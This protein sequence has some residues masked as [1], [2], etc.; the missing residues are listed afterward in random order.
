[1]M[2]DKHIDLYIDRSSTPLHTPKS[3][4]VRTGDGTIAKPV[5]TVVGD[6]IDYEKFMVVYNKCMAKLP[7]WITDLDADVEVIIGLKPGKTA[8]DGGWLLGY[9]WKRSSNKWDRSMGIYSYTCSTILHEIGHL[10][11]S[12]YRGYGNTMDLSTIKSVHDAGETTSITPNELWADSFSDYFNEGVC[13]TPE[14]TEWFRS[15]CKEMG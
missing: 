4:K 11:L 15:F 9:H 7:C 5:I 10:W 14:L 1:M 6:V 3:I 2:S 13:E 8:S 12:L